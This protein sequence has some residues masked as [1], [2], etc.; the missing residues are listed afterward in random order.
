[1]DA[2]YVL[3]KTQITFKIILQHLFK[4]EYIFFLIYCCISVYTA[5]NYALNFCIQ[6][7][8]V[9]IQYLLTS[10]ADIA[11]KWYSQRFNVNAVFGLSRIHRQYILEYIYCVAIEVGGAQTW[12][13]GALEEIGEI[14]ATLTLMVAWNYSATVIPIRL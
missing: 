13:I 8:F 4:R 11:I 6:L 7:C 10:R 5:L 9:Y 1:M 14:A 2:L 3:C 12:H